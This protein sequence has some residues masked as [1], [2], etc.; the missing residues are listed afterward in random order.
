MFALSASCS[1]CVSTCAQRF[2]DIVI[3]STILLSVPSCLSSYIFSFK[4]SAGCMTCP[5]VSCLLRFILKEAWRLGF[6]N[7]LGCFVSNTEHTEFHQRAV[8]SDT[9]CT[10]LQTWFLWSQAGRVLT[11][12][13]H[14]NLLLAG[15]LQA[16]LPLL[17]WD[18]SSRWEPRSFLICLFFFCGLCWMWQIV[19]YA[20]NRD[21]TSMIVVNE[22]R[23]YPSMFS[24]FPCSKSLSALWIH[25]GHFF[26]TFV[27]WTAGQ[28]DCWLSTCL[29]GPQHILS[30]Q[31]W[32]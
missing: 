7:S 25:G 18:F 21:F 22:D 5:S 17:C 15:V 27:T 26:L 31:V 9:K 13:F 1:L 10:L 14:I 19:K 2:G 20:K 24:S 16:L 23:K 30:S 12:L 11:S 29:M 32:S 6:F 8:D 4:P 3:V 28:M